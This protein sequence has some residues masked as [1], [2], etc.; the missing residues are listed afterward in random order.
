MSELTNLTAIKREAFIL[1]FAKTG[2]ISAACKKAKISRDTVYR[3]KRDDAAFAEAWGEAES[4]YVEILEAEADRRAKTGT[5]K[6]VFYQ[7]QEVGKVR[8]YSDTLLM[9]RLKALRPDKYRDNSSVKHSGAVEVLG[10]D[11]LMGSNS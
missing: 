1:A 4:I 8:E 7:G 11:Y 3:H 5:L 2:N 6:P 10:I 9:F